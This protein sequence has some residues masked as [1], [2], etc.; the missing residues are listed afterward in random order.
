MDS[1]NPLSTL[2]RERWLEQARDGV[3]RLEQDPRDPVGRGLLGEAWARLG[4]DRPPWVHEAHHRLVVPVAPQLPIRTERLLLRRVSS[5]DAADLHSY[6]GRADVAAYLLTPPLSRAET[7]VEVER[8]LRLNQDD[9]P[10]GPGAPEA[11]GLVLELDGRVVGDV[12]LIHKGPH[13][14]QAEVGWVIHPDHAGRGLVTEAMRA[15]LD[16][17]FVHHGF[18]RVYAEL[19][20][21][22]TRSAAM[23]ERLGMRLEAH[24]VKDF[25]SKGEWTDSFRYAVLGMD[26]FSRPADL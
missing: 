7:E 26:F 15:L 25:W 20:A 16:I 17:A 10:D 24:G 2:H 1:V 6:Y 8:R 14:S 23:C 4:D 9:G 11:L 22:N 18:H 12:V 3:S 5:S 13:Y 19:D 21:R